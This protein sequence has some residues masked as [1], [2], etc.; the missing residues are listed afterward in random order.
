MFCKYCGKSI[1]ADA[2]FCS[3]CG[4][5]LIKEAEETKTVEVVKESE[6]VQEPVCN[7]NLEAYDAPEKIIIE[8]PTKGE[9]RPK[10]S[11]TF[12]EAIKNFYMNFSN[13]SGRAVRTEG[14]YVFL[15]NIIVALVLELVSAP[16]G[17]AFAWTIIHLI[18]GIALSVRRLHDVGKSGAWWWCGL[19]PIAGVFIMLYFY[20]CDSDYDNEWGLSPYN[21]MQNN[22]GHPNEPYHGYSAIRKGDTSIWRCS[23]GARI[24]VSP[25]PFCGKE[26][27]R[28]DLSETGL[29]EYI[30]NA[31]QSGEKDADTT[32][33]YKKYLHCVYDEADDVNVDTLSYVVNNAAVYVPPEYIPTLINVCEN[34]LLQLQYWRCKGCGKILPLSKYICHCGYKK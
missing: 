34:R 1:D 9:E 2:K 29:K 20:C 8:E 15:Y 25:C 19:I 4:K 10:K 33:F 32:E 31:V 22:N 23:C 14:W 24:S 7:V 21:T 3:S 6:H 30:T 26:Y 12:F 13:F 28:K 18:P 17:F 5:M 11:V 27:K 16:D